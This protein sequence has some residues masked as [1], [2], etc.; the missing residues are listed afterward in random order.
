MVLTRRGRWWLAT[1]AIRP[2]SET[3]GWIKGEVAVG[4]VVML[5]RSRFRQHWKSWLALSVLVAVAGGFVLATAA[6]G[7]RTAAAFGDFVARHGY[8]VVVYSGQ[9]VPRL[10]RLP[11][12][13][14]VTPVLAPYSGTPV[15]A[16]CRHPIDDSTFLINEVP[17]GQLPRGPALLSAVD[18]RLPGG[19][20][21]I[22]LGAATMRA[23]K[24]RLGGT[25]RVTITDPAGKPHEARFRVIGRASLNAGA[26]GLGHGAVITTS[27]FIGAQCPGG[28]HSACAN[29]VRQGMA[30]TAVLVRAAPGAAGSA[31]LA[32]HIRKYPSLTYR[33][34]KPTVL[35]N[36]G[37][38]VN[39]PLLLGVA[40]S[41]FGTATLVHLLL[42]S[43]VRRRVETGLLKALGFVGRQVAAVV[44]WQATAVALTGIVIGVPLGIAAG[45]VFWRVFA[46][47]F[48]VVP[49]DVVE[50]LL[51]AALVAGVLAAA[52][53][54][55]AVPALLAARSHPAQLLRAE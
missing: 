33:P 30:A 1:L 26:G 43:V 6:A 23:T 50:P 18:G 25:V 35:V 4:A 16:S 31:A 11:Q 52:N 3:L 7:H 28:G 47:N 22:M 36:F 55:A 10:A 24:A 13:A 9:P 21:D 32:R 46:T 39:F 41:L 37:E 51:M 29:A 27:A 54:V 42:V 14:S 34:V 15:C 44:C 17:P 19:D 8:D 20:R 5:L 53:V 2:G 48:G 40:L 49:V 12:V 38:S 45:R